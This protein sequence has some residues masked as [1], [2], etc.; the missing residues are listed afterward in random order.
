MPKPGFF[1]TLSSQLRDSLV[2]MARHEL[3]NALKEGQSD[4]A[5]HEEKLQ[6]ASGARR[7]CSGSST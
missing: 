2:T 7:R 4:T 5:S 3:P 1:W 6:A